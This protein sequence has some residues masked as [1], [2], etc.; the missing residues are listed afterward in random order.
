MDVLKSTHVPSDL[1][2]EVQAR[3]L[4]QYH[5]LERFPVRVG[6]AL[7]ND[8]IIS[9]PTVSPYHLLIDLDDEGSL[10]LRNL[11]KENGSRLNYY[12]LKEA[13]INFSRPIKPL[14]LRLGGRRLTLMRADTPV[15]QTAVRKCRG[16]YRL[17][18]EP[19]WSVVLVIAML[20]AFLYEN[21][22]DTIF[23]KDAVYYF[24]NLMPYVMGSLAITLVVAGISRLSLQRWEVGA[25]A[26]LASLLLLI[27]H[28]LGQLG[29]WLNYLVT[30]DWP[31]DYI[32]L[33]S[34]FL[35]VPLLLYAYIRLIHHAS[36]FPALGVALLFSA[37]IIVYQASE[38]A[39]NL[40]LKKEFSGEA[41]FNRTLSSGDF[42]L[43][44][45]QSI[46]DYLK[47]M[48]QSL[49]AESSES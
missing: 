32:L 16:L 19:V 11:S 41:K 18:C 8:I 4:N 25:A 21:Y 35:L 29:H 13:R 9:D 5:R 20:L 43:K 1:I 36:F 15:E 42:R 40:T 3:G 30:A 34:N 31:L 37:P 10:I 27:P 46:D 26:S 44:P 47:E 6:R 14:A 23:A 24:G 2:L 38:L 48:Q 49:N 28:S 33:V 45:T 12:P 7:D 22:L 39:D 17:L